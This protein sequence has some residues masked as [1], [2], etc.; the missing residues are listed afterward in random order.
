MQ[1]LAAGGGRQPPAVAWAAPIAL[2]LCSHAV[3][4]AAH[5]KK[6]PG[7]GH[8]C[9]GIGLA[10]ADVGKG[11]IHILRVARAFARGPR[12]GLPGLALRGQAQAQA[13]QTVSRA[14]QAALRQRGA[15]HIARRAALAD[16]GRAIQQPRRQRPRRLGLRHMPATAGQARQQRKIGRIA[17]RARAHVQ[18]AAQRALAIQR[19]LRP[20]EQLHARRARQRL[21]RHHGQLRHAIHI[22]RQRG[23]VEVL[24]R[25]HA[26]HGEDGKH[27]IGAVPRV[28]PRQRLVQRQRAARAR[29]A[30]S[31]LTRHRHRA[32]EARQRLRP[33]GRCNHHFRQSVFAGGMA[34]VGQSAIRAVIHAVMR[35][36]IR[37]V[38]R[39][40]FRAASWRASQQQARRRA[41]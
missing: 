26:P 30:Q 36:A 14:A 9:I 39:A 31:L 8:A 5:V 28:K 18:H 3:G 13:P 11:H 35:V 20:L 21:R 34:A 15:A 29:I 4:A 16:H 24:R 22:H 27:H 32:I 6:A 1:A 37:A 2:A 23:V 17:R 25:S 7:R 19:A 12:A 33:L 38:I 41:S 10:G 40:A